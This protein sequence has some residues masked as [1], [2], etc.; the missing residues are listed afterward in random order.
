MHARGPPAGW[1]GGEGAREKGGAGTG[2]RGHRLPWAGCSQQGDAEDKNRAGSQGA[3]P[4]DEFLESSS[5]VK[6]K[7]GQDSP[8]HHTPRASRPA[9]GSVLLSK[10]AELPRTTEQ[11]WISQRNP[12]LGISGAAH[13]GLSLSRKGAERPGSFPWV[14][15]LQ[16]GPALSILLLF[17]RT[18]V[19]KSP[20]FAS[21]CVFTHADQPRQGADTKTAK[22]VTK[23]LWGPLACPR[24]AAWPAPP[25]AQPFSLCYGGENVISALIPVPPL[26][27]AL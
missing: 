23:P 16:P 19:P 26:C 3:R 11:L 6:A 2:T 18:Q 10:G 9:E 7:A 14:T 21:P 20:A 24:R 5:G 27:P 8:Q 12:P 22:R 25:R 15:S 13:K 4:R 17:P 1:G